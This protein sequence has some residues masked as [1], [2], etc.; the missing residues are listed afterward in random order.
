MGDLI[1]Y[2]YIII[3][4]VHEKSYHTPLF[5]EYN[6]HAFESELK[7]VWSKVPIKLPFPSH[8][9]AIEHKLE[10]V[11]CKDM[12]NVQLTWSKKHAPLLTYQHI[13]MQ[14]PLLTCVSNK[15]CWYHWWDHWCY[16][17][18]S[19]STHWRNGRTS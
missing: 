12:V 10:E 5:S 14:K 7:S 3:R 15:Y 6:M 19:N 17:W 11:R 8:L 9:I 2:N 4:N 1:D 18:W 16:I 13:W